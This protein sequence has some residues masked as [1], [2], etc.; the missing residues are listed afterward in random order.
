MR[1]KLNAKLKLNKE[2]LRVLGAHDLNGVLG[3]ATRFT[4]DGGG[5]S[6]QTLSCPDD[7]CA[8]CNVSQAVTCSCAETV[9]TC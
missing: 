5:C 9:C 3:G 4:C 8:G 2:T 1:K 6:G 7:T